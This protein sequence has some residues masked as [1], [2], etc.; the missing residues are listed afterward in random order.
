[1][2]ISDELIYVQMPKTGCTHIAEQLSRILNG[3][4]VGKHNAP[5]QSQ[6][7]SKV[8]FIS[9]IRNP[10]SW[11]LSLWSYGLT[12]KSGLQRRLTKQ[13][14]LGQ[15]CSQILRPKNNHYDRWKGLFHDPREWRRVYN[16]GDSPQAFRIWLKMILQPPFCRDVGEG[17][18]QSSIVNSC[19]FMSYRYLYLCTERTEILYPP[20]LKSLEELIEHDQKNCYI[21]F[22]IR[23]ENLKK[24]L[25][26]AIKQIHP[27]SEKQEEFIDQGSKTNSSTTLYSLKDY[28]DK[29]TIELVNQREKLIIDKFSYSYPG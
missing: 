2:F 10:W 8:A 15:V 7:N 28:Y 5:N 16:L 22:F 6:L 18:Q 20:H 12:G 17:Y 29:G 13:K 14:H 25:I 4:I 23:Q 19:G 1:M 3:R 24:D 27:L 9:S 21:N 11:Y 26:Y